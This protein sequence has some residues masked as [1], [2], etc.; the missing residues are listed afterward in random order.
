MLCGLVSPILSNVYLHYVLDVWFE[1][2]FARSCH[3]NAWLVRYADDYVACFT[4]ESEAKRFMSEM[5]ERLE[6][7]GLEVELSK[8][9]LLRFGNR[10]LA[11]IEN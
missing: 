10:M 2:K 11:P 5:T 6:K 9:A 4:Y 8:T 7:F 1:K 3:G